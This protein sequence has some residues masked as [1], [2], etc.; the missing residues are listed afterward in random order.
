MANMDIRTPR[1]YTDT[2]NFLMSVGTEQDGN[3]DVVSGTNLIN[4]YV[5]GSEAE[6]FDMR[7]MNQVTFNTTA[8]AG[9]QA[10][11]VL[12]NINK[13]STNFKTD[14]IA[15]LNHNMVSAEAKFRVGFGDALTDINDVDLANADSVMA[16]AVQAVNADTISSNFV[17]PGTNGSTVV[18]FDET[19]AQYVGIQFEGIGGAGNLFNGSNNLKIGCIIIGEHYTMPNAPDL[20]V[21]RS[22]LYDGVSVQQSIG[23]QKFGNATH[24]GRRHINTLNKSPFLATTY[25]SGVYGGRIIYDMNFSYLNST[26]VMP[27][28]YLTEIET[29]E[30]VVSDVWNRTKGNLIPFIFS[31]DSTSQLDT[32]YMFARFAQSSLDMTQVAPDVF[33]MSFRIEEEF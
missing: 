22:I 13:Q 3:F 8:S 4:T 1:F 24:L 10:E 21:K 28:R 33:N 29:D 27:S 18:T 15:I 20:S 25:P 11:H 2:I 23:G 12:I 17:T 19:D 5:T 6:L 7:P 9:V 14:F 32:D 26:D 30:T 31:N 16:N